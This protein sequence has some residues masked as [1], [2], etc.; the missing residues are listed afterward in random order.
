MN[1]RVLQCK[2]AGNR[3]IQLVCVEFMDLN[4]LSTT[5]PTNP[6]ITTN[7]CGVAKPMIRLTHPG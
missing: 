3:T 5:V 7:L 6:F 4:V 2:T 1:P